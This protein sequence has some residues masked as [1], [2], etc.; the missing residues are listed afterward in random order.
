VDLEDPMTLNNRAWQLATGQ[1]DRRDPA[2]A[3]RLITLAVKR[4]PTR[5]VYLNTLGVV[6][7]RNGMYREALATLEK[8]L[9]ASKGATDAFDLFFLA[10]CHA[11]LGDPVRARDAFDRA[12]KWVEAQT[13]LP[14]KHAEELKAFRAEAEAELTLEDGN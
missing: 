11:K 13:A 9:A 5:P 7:Y 2:E 4:E 6:Q 14:P 1:A 10:M 12:V 3:L 8:S